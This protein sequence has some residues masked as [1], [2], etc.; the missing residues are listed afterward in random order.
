MK[1]NTTKLS[2]LLGFANELHETMTSSTENAIREL[3]LNMAEQVTNEMQIYKLSSRS[4]ETAR[5]REVVQIRSTHSKVEQDLKLL[6]PAMEGVDKADITRFIS[7][8]IAEKADTLLMRLTM[9]LVGNAKRIPLRELTHLWVPFLSL[10]LEVLEKHQLPLSTPRYQNIFAAILEV[11]LLKR[12][13]KAPKHVWQPAMRSI[14]CRCGLCLRVNQFL[15]ESCSFDAIRIRGSSIAFDH[16][17]HYLMGLRE[18]ISCDFTVDAASGTLTVTKRFK[19][20][21]TA[22][23]EWETKKKKVKNEIFA[24]FDQAKLRA[25]LGAEYLW[26]TGFELLDNVVETEVH[27]EN[28]LPSPPVPPVPIVGRPVDN[29]IIGRPDLS[30]PS[31]QGYHPPVAAHHNPHHPLHQPTSTSFGYQGPQSGQALAQPVGTYYVLKHPLGQGERPPANPWA[32][33]GP[34]T[35]PAQY[36]Q[37]FQS[38]PP[39]N[40]QSAVSI[41]SGSNGFAGSIQMT[42][43]V[44][45]QQLT[46]QINGSSG[47]ISV[48]QNSSIQNNGYNYQTTHVQSNLE[49]GR[50]LFFSEEATVIQ[51]QFPS[52]NSD[53]ILAELRRRWTAMPIDLVESYVN[54][55][56]AVL[57]QPQAHCHPSFPAP[58]DSAP[59]HA[60]PSLTADDDLKAGREYYI[61]TQMGSLRAQHPTYSHQ[62]LLNTV[63]PAWNALPRSHRE[64]F[65]KQALTQKQQQPQLPPLDNTRTMGSSRTQSIPSLSS[66][67]PPPPPAA[68]IQMPLTFFEGRLAVMRE[69][70]KVKPTTAFAI[71]KP[72]VDRHGMVIVRMGSTTQVSI[73]EN[74]YRESKARLA[75]YPDVAHLDPCRKQLER[76]RTWWINKF[77]DDFLRLQYLPGKS[78]QQISELLGAEWES[79]LGMSDRLRTDDLGQIEDAKSGKARDQNTLSA[80]D[81]SSL[82]EFLSGWGN[83]RARTSYGG[84]TRRVGLSRTQAV[85]PLVGPSTGSNAWNDPPPSSSDEEDPASWKRAGDILP[86][87]RM[88][89]KRP[90]AT[91]AASVMAS[92]SVASAPISGYEVFAEELEAQLRK[93]HPSAS[94]ENLRSVIRKRWESMSESHRAVY[95]TMAIDKAKLGSGTMT[96]SSSTPAAPSSTSSVSTSR[97]YDGFELYLNVEGPRVKRQHPE[98]SYDQV[99]ETMRKRWNAMWPSKRIK[100]NTDAPVFARDQFKKAVF[101]ELEDMFKNEDKGKATASSKPAAPSTSASTSGSSRA[102]QADGFEFWIKFEERRF[103]QKNPKLTHEQAV[104]ALRTQ[105]DGMSNVAQLMYKE[106]AAKANANTNTTAKPTASQTPASSLA[107]A[108]TAIAAPSSAP[109]SSTAASITREEWERKYDGFNFYLNIEGRN[110][111][112]THETYDA[113]VAAMKAKWQELF[114]HEQASWGMLAESWRDHFRCRKDLFNE[115]RSALLMPLDPDIPPPPTITTVA[116]PEEAITRYPESFKAPKSIRWED[117]VK[118]YD[119]YAWFLSSQGHD[120]KQKHL[121]ID[122]GVVVEIMESRWKS[123]DEYERQK[124]ES[125]ARA[126]RTSWGGRRLFSKLRILCG[127]PEMPDVVQPAKTPAKPRTPYKSTWRGSGSKTASSLLSSS[128]TRPDPP[129]SSP[130][131]QRGALTETQPNRMAAA[132]TPGLSDKVAE[133]DITSAWAVKSG[134]L[135]IPPLGSTPR[136]GAGSGSASASAAASASRGVKRK[137]QADFIDLTLDD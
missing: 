51:R 15:S 68:A 45:N 39:Q 130:A 20:D 120:F 21:P 67:T 117:W 60:G 53:S 131:D 58:F 135:K 61:S 62:L 78:E 64:W 102:R 118:M 88:T 37:K 54:K 129:A 122:Y 109:S 113:I 27:D 105:W 81:R 13:G 116:A 19:P 38:G 6:K 84:S 101:D 40:I 127:L 70:A 86:S 57:N 69:E 108:A 3:Y 103:K 17:Q 24:K 124:Y 90:S 50:Q 8:L 44:N 2:F 121:D 42:N 87:T 96:S 89:G 112:E 41:S 47:S 11:Y 115:L 59:Q 94:A 75:P 31:S 73:P 10:L 98:Y 36:G 76:G 48:I 85:G 114:P 28:E 104:A 93:S 12:V 52:W 46:T 14:S 71:A 30:T 83:K 9:K 23:K 95:A 132:A 110:L 136:S 1:R 26:F 55:A 111:V 92:S 32:Y 126:F 63:L 34:S 72:A 137:A 97:K 33:A 65:N 134:K 107:T 35:Q 82:N 91:T 128:P 22:L 18:G 123:M 125:S 66:I 7:G 80:Q 100:W 49:R 119:G 4:A 79:S 56:T 74:D 106:M 25:I 5:L 29:F 77:K 133:I 43:N 16:V 99:V